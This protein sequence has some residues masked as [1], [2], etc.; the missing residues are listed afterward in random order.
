MIIWIGDRGEAVVRNGNHRSAA[1]QRMEEPYRTQNRRQ[2]AIVLHHDTPDAVI[3][4]IISCKCD[5]DRACGVHTQ[6]WTTHTTR[7][8][9]S[10]R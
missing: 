9:P 4:R 3:S 6:R 7:T 1:I 2:R 8:S 5:T 10:P